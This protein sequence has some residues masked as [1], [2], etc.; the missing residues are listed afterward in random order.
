MTVGVW[1]QQTCVTRYTGVHRITNLMLCYGEN[2]KGTCQGDSGG[3]LNC[4]VDGRWHTYGATSFGVQCAGPI[5]P[6][7]TARISQFSAWIWQTID[8]NT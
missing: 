7:A 8:A 3:P 1:R 5:Y 2:Q 4:Y 6:S